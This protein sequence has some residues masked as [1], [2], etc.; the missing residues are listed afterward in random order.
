MEA[1]HQPS[2]VLRQISR[3]IGIVVTVSVVMQSGL[4][5]KVLLLEAE[6][7]PDPLPVP[8]AYLAHTFKARCITAWRSNLRHDYRL[9][10]ILEIVP[11]ISF[12]DNRKSP[13]D[14]DKKKQ[15]SPDT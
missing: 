12:I 10:L 14:P 9:G 8:L 11:S 15:S 3:R 4:F 5:I 13:D 1:T 6:R 7:L 2:R